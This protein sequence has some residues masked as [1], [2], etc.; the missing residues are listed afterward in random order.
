VTDPSLRSIVHADN[1]YC[2]SI[3]RFAWYPA[4]DYFEQY[5]PGVL[6][7][8]NRRW[9]AVVLELVPKP[10]PIRLAFSLAL[11]FKPLASHPATAFGAD[12][13]QDIGNY[14]CNRREASQCDR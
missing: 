1:R 12:P 5:A 10:T 14:F 4:G 9:T 7:L 8:V 6:D 11:E 13:I 3:R 2:A